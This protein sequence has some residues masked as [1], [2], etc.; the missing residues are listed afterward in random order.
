MTQFFERGKLRLALHCR[1]L[2]G[3][4][5]GSSVGLIFGTFSSAFGCNTV[6]LSSFFFHQGILLARVLE[7]KHKQ[8][9]GT[10]RFHAH[11]TSCCR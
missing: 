5:S 10:S 8:T 7:K 2:A 3:R 4:H 1:Q 11:N 6:D 9:P